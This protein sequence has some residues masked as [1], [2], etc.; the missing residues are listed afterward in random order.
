MTGQAPRSKAMKKINKCLPLNSRAGLSFHYLLS[1]KVSHLELSRKA[2]MAVHINNKFV[3][4]EYV[5]I[6]KGLQNIKKQHNCNKV[7]IIMNDDGSG[8]IQA[9]DKTKSIG[10]TKTMSFK[11][12]D[13]LLGIFQEYFFVK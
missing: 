3:H 8:E 4:P 1:Y 9:Y 2:I 11:N 10:F 7:R 13:E 5:E 6:L 12:Y